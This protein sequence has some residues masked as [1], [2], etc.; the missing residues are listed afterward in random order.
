MTYG[1]AF[2]REIDPGSEKWLNTRSHEAILAANRK[3]GDLLVPVDIGRKVLVATID[4]PSS[5]QH[6]FVEMQ[7]LLEHSRWNQV[8]STS[9]HP[10]YG[11]AEW[12]EEPAIERVRLSLP[13]THIDQIEQR[14]CLRQARHRVGG[15]RTQ[16]YPM[17][18]PLAKLIDGA[19]KL[20]DEILEIA[21]TV[22]RYVQ[23]MSQNIT[24]GPLTAEIYVPGSDLRGV[25]A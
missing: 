5:N 3:L 10:F 4:Y 6:R 16:L 17:V 2:T 8:V 12:L 21:G 7:T 1:V 20:D 22:S 18:Y 23:S 14:I 13:S 25:A 9:A 11:P 19:P 24:L 15:S